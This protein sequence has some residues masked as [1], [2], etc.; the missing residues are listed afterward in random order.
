MFKSFYIR[1]EYLFLADN[2]CYQLIKVQ[3]T[4]NEARQACMAYND[5][6]YNLVTIESELEQSMYSVLI[7]WVIK[8]IALE[9]YLCGSIQNRD[10]SISS[11]SLG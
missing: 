2:K 1:N 9:R 5:K 10:Y 8:G 3:K 7:P 4:W 11:N 6:T